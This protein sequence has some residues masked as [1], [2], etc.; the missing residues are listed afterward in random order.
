MTGS[1]NCGM[2]IFQFIIQIGPSTWKSA[3]WDEFDFDFSVESWKSWRDAKSLLT[4]CVSLF[5]PLWF[6]GNFNSRQRLL[7]ASHLHYHWL[8]TSSRIQN[9]LDIQFSTFWGL[10]ISSHLSSNGVIIWNS[11]DCARVSSRTW[12]KLRFIW[13][14]S[15]A[16]RVEINTFPRKNFD[17]AWCSSSLFV[18]FAWCRQLKSI[19]LSLCA[20][21]QWQLSEIDIADKL[22]RAACRLYW[23]K[24]ITMM[25]EPES[26]FPINSNLILH[27]II[28]CRGPVT[29]ESLQFAGVVVSFSVRIKFNDR[30]RWINVYALRRFNR[31]LIYAIILIL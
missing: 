22:T 10:K 18:P 4:F 24:R 14:L 2:R 6:E 1:W 28:V 25:T 31:R 12:K 9:F 26:Q 21:L 30:W 29:R 11:F 8:E 27:V 19:F 20:N 13:Q 17:F 7:C 23:L 3:V 5:P 16:H 15:G